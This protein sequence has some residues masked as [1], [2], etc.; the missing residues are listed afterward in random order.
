MPNVLYSEADE[1]AGI[2]KAEKTTIHTFSQMPTNTDLQSLWDCPLE[3]FDQD[4]RD[5]DH[6]S[7]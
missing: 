2:V 4:Y 6:F 5:G 3:S 1:N 7:S